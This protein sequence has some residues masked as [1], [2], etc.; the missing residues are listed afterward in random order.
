M[1][2]G[3][4]AICVL[5]NVVSSLELCER[6]PL[7]PSSAT[8]SLRDRLT[9]LHFAPLMAKTVR[10]QDQI[11][12]VAEML[13]GRLADFQVFRA[14]TRFHLAVECHFD[15]SLDLTLSS[16]IV[17]LFARLRAPVDMDP[18]WTGDE[19]YV[20]RFAYS[21]PFYYGEAFV[22]A[23]GSAARDGIDARRELGRHV[24][25]AL[26]DAPRGAL[27]EFDIRGGCGHPVSLF[28][29]RALRIAA[30]NDSPIRLRVRP[31]AES[32]SPRPATGPL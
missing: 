12:A 5:T 28:S 30:D 17:R 19:D 2:E 27:V 6:A 29:A 31:T 16:Q 20:E 10:L 32:R 4:A 8:S 26:S 22:A 23:G 14:F 13:Q 15:E 25:R 11:A 7:P 3:F 9:H 21:S 18:Y 1:D 24:A